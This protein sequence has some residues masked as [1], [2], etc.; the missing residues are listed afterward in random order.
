MIYKKAYAATGQN[1][2]MHVYSSLFANFGIE[3]AQILVTKEDFRSGY[4]LNSLAST[5]DYLLESKIVPILNTNDSI[6]YPPERTQDVAGALN[7]NDNDTLAAK[8]ATIIKSDL[9]LIMSDVDGVY[10]R[11]PKETGARFFN[12]FVP[13]VHRNAISFG[14]NSN[15]GTGG[16]ESKIRAAS[17]AVKNNCSV[18]ICNGRLENAIIDSVKGKKIGTFITNE[19]EMNARSVENMALQGNFSTLFQFN[20]M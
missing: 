3:T 16:M 11:H 4:L 14:E 19:I 17:F 6:A 15:V 8:L 12:T 9:L 5:L 7:I 20:N 2:L 13:D 1:G 18:I 10:D